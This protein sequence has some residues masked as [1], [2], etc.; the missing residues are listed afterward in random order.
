M[1]L[2]PGSQI[3]HGKQLHPRYQVLDSVNKPI[4]IGDCVVLIMDQRSVYDTKRECWWNLPTTPFSSCKWTLVGGSEIVAFTKKRVYS[5]KMKLDVQPST[6]TVL[7]HTKTM[8]SSILFSPKYS[9]V[10]F[11]CPDG[12]EIPAHRSAL[13]ANSP[14]FDTYFSGPWTEQH[15]DGRWETNK[16]SDVIKALLS[17]IYTGEVPFD[18]SDAHLLELLEAVY[19]FQLDG[20][21]LRVCQAKCMENITLVNVKPLLLSSKLHDASFLFDA[22]FKYVCQHFVQ[23]GSKAQFAMDVINVDGGQLWQEIV[24]SGERPNRK[25]PRDV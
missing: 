2:K 1:Y 14:Y 3:Q 6:A 17:L 11:V 7:R 22:C 12:T 5:L 25:R 20:D 24:E 19:E 4:V 15:P 13:G 16:S 10:T 23:L 9:D 21:L 8:W 18:L